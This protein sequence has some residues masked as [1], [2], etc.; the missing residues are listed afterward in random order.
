MTRGADKSTIFHLF[1]V[2][3]CCFFFEWKG[4]FGSPG[5]IRANVSSSIVGEAS[6]WRDRPTTMFTTPILIGLLIL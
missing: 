3:E 2:N 5:A 1:L 6:S 4:I